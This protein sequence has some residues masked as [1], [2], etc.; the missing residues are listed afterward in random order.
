M[1]GDDQAPGVADLPGEPAEAVVPG[2]VAPVDEGAGVGA[3]RHHVA[4]ARGD[5]LAQEYQQVVARRVR[6]V[7]VRGVR[8]VLAAVDEVQAGRAGQRGDLGGVRRPSEYQE[9]RW[10]SPRYQARPR[11]LARSGGYT[12]RT[13][14][15]GFP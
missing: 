2:A 1:G 6:P 10:Q 13:L 12:G 15:P 11:P 7:G 5:L 9:C 8:V 14:R 4:V 3:D